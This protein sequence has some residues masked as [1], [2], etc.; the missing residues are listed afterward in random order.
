[1][2]R[3]DYWHPKLERNIARDIRNR[4]DLQTIGWDIL[5]IWECETKHPELLERQI[6][7][8]LSG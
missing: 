2:T 4:E 7:D 1:M 6:R 5:V 3:T 8:Y